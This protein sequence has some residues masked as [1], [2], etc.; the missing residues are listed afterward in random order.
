MTAR[1]FRLLGLILLAAGLALAA[2]SADDE[3]IDAGGDQDTGADD[4]SIRDEGAN[5][6]TAETAGADDVDRSSPPPLVVRNGDDEVALPAFSYC[7]NEG[8]PGICA[9]GQPTEPLPAFDAGQPLTIGF[10]IPGWDFTAG[11]LSNCQAGSWT[12]TPVGDIEWELAATG[13][14][15]RSLLMIF[16]RG[17]QGDAAYALALES[18]GDDGD[19]SDDGIGQAPRGTIQLLDL[20][21]PERSGDLIVGLEGPA[22]VL[23]IRSIEV[24]ITGQGTIEPFELVVSREVEGGD[25]E[26]HLSRMVGGRAAGEAAALAGEPPWTYTVTVITEADA[27]FQATVTQEPESVTAGHDDGF[28]QLYFSPI[29]LPEPDEPGGPIDPDVSE[30]EVVGAVERFLALLADGDYEAAA[31]AA[32]RADF[33]YESGVMGQAITAGVVTAGTPFS[34]QL[35]EWCSVAR[36][37]NPESITVTGVNEFGNGYEVLATW[38]EGSTAR[39][40]VAVLEG[41]NV[42]GLPPRQ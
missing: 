33:D 39:F 11:S 31:T 41:L 24:A 35:R 27:A 25:G 20:S 12:L 6:D 9:D 37:T 8:D 13:I 5:D 15:D 34:D 4:D 19:D 36:C 22:E 28:R 38:P 16:G 21:G 2:C 26:C 18:A 30:A 32:L 42:L 17:P 14:V 7:W 29:D 3:T 40:E 23:D 1:H 10:E